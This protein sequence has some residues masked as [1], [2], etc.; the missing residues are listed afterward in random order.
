MELHVHHAKLLTAQSSNN[1]SPTEEYGGVDSAW[2]MSSGSATSCENN[3]SSFDDNFELMWRKL[4]PYMMK[5]SSPRSASFMSKTRTPSE[6]RK[7]NDSGTD[8]LVTRQSKQSKQPSCSVSCSDVDAES[9]PLPVTALSPQPRRV[10]ILRQPRDLP[11]TA[12][13][14]SEIQEKCY[15]VLGSMKISEVLKLLSE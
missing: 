14:M 12:S 10:S 7:R 13:S 9:L 4:P 8:E 5:T 2:I 15:E 3:F 6:S 1:P 11:A